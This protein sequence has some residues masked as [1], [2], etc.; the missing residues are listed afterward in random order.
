MKAAKQIS[1]QNEDN[2]AD[3]EEHQHKT[4]HAVNKDVEKKITDKAGR[5]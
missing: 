2:I 4:I 3:V 5:G 1:I